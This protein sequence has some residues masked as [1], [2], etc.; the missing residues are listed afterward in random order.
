MR[1]MRL[2]FHPRQRFYFAAVLICFDFWKAFTG[3]QTTCVPPSTSSNE[4]GGKKCLFILLFRFNSN[5]NVFAFVRFREFPMTKS[6]QMFVDKQFSDLYF[7]SLQCDFSCLRD[8]ASSTTDISSD[9][10]K[11]RFPKN[12]SFGEFNFS[13]QWIFLGE[14]FFF[15]SFLN[16]S[17]L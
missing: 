11:K 16:K 7:V 10:R 4:R 2:W 14:D 5:R 13:T 1:L 8:F 15:V 12:V 6:Q 17:W 3:K 9:W